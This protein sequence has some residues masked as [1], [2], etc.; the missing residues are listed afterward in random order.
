MDRMTRGEDSGRVAE[1]AG[2]QLKQFAAAQ[3]EPGWSGLEDRESS[4]TRA[5]GDMFSQ[6]DGGVHR[7]L[8]DGAA[9][10]V[11]FEVEV[12]AGGVA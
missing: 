2:F 12:A 9:A 10:G 5:L 7:V 6:P 8:V 1:Y 4:S 3:R 11:N